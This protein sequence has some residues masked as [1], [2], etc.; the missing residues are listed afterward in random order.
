MKFEHLAAAACEL[1]GVGPALE[2]NGWVETLDGL[3]D[4]QQKRL[5]RGWIALHRLSS[6]ETDLEHAC[7]LTLLE[8]LRDEWLKV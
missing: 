2:L 7:I 5:M 6:G 3:T 4:H 1:G 8:A